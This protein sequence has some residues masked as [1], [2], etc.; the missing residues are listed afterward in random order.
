[1]VR[2]HEH[3]Y[4]LFVQ[5]HGIGFMLSRTQRHDRDIKAFAVDRGAFGL[6]IGE[7]GFHFIAD[8]EMRDLVVVV[9]TPG[10]VHHRQV[11]A[12]L[13]QLLQLLLPQIPSHR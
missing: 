12:G 3:D 10:P 2:G 4:R 9:E 6:Q 8:V 1:M 13:L 7:V 5:R 11:D